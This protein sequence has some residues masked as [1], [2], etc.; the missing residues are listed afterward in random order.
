MLW[1]QRKSKEL[2][3]EFCERCAGVCDA[4]CRAVAVREQARASRY[5]WRLV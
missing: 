1:L 5:G 3:V 4:T 2:A